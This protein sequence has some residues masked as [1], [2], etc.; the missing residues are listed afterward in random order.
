MLLLVSEACFVFFDG[1]LFYL[2]R[3]SQV[4]AC[5]FLA[6]SSRFRTIGKNDGRR[7]GLCQLINADL[8]DL[9]ELTEL[10]FNLI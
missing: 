3:H 2:C 4:D 10:I 8:T 6:G 5:N 9:T 1:V 7:K